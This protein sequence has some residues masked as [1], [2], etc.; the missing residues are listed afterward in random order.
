MFQCYNFAGRQQAALRPCGAPD[1]GRVGGV[2]SI[3]GVRGAIATAAAGAGTAS[4]TQAQGRLM[5]ACRYDL[6]PYS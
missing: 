1:G 6:F 5:R 2:G 3:R 4:H